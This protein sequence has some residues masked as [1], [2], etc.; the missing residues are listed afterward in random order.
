MKTCLSPAMIIMLL[1]GLA[2][3]IQAQNMNTTYIFALKRSAGGYRIDRLPLRMGQPL[4]LNLQDDLEIID[5]ILP[6]GPGGSGNLVQ[7]GRVASINASYDGRAIN[8]D[9]LLA[10]GEH[11]SY[12]AKKV[13]DLQTLDTHISVT[14]GDGS[15]ARFIIRGYATVQV[16]SIGPVLDMFGGRIP[17]QKGDY[18]IF[19]N[20]DFAAPRYAVTGEMPLFYS[21]KYLFVDVILPDDRRGRFVVDI[22]AATSTLTQSFLPD[23]AEMSEVFMMEYAGGSARKLKYAPGGATGSVENVIGNVTLQTV[24]IGG[25]EFKQAEFDVIESLPL[26]DN[27]EVDGIIGLDLLKSARFLT[28]TYAAN[29][30]GEARLLLSNESSERGNSILLRFVN[31]RKLMYV[32]GEI[33]SQPV[34]FILDSGSPDCMLQPQAVDAL[35][36]VVALDSSRTFKGGGGQVREGRHGIIRSMSLGEAR[37]A[38]IPCVIGELSVFSTLGQ[39]QLAGLIGNSLFSRF[40]RVTIDFQKN[41]VSLEPVQ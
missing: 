1:M 18:S 30:D 3:P 16:D 35:T 21:G 22:G 40:A 33:N 6:V 5:I 12:P 9:Y 15:S 27:R 17:M 38:D 14:G 25:L 39:G 31:I 4:T 34:H 7:G 41:T 37:F 26:L 29:S 20:T 24:T 10:N 36:E 8:V 2:A 28:L 13:V 23:S 11:Q 32:R 19:T